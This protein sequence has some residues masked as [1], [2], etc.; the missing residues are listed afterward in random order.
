MTI[1]LR[2]CYPCRECNFRRCFSLQDAFYSQECVLLVFVGFKWWWRN[3]PL[4]CWLE[5]RSQDWF[6]EVIQRLIYRTVTD[7]YVRLTSL[8]FWDFTNASNEVTE[9]V[10][11][12]W[13]FDQEQ[14]FSFEHVFDAG[15]LLYLSES[16]L[17]AILSCSNPFIYLFEDVQNT[18]LS[19]TWMLSLHIPHSFD[20]FVDF[21]NIS[22]LFA[23][24]IC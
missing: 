18:N 9:R 5:E 19:L 4:H 20:F 8:W 15:I 12:C 10:F 7:I 16:K 2:I 1:W 21:R 11:V 13:W 3:L 6:S 24:R 17:N 23:S 22:Q 14:I